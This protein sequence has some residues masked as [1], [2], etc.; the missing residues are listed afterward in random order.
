[1]QSFKNVLAIADS[2]DRENTIFAQAAHLAA[3]NRALLTV[4]A[5]I[6]SIPIVE[7]CGSDRQSPFLCD[8]QLEEQI[9][10]RERLRLEALAA[11]VREAGFEIKTRILRGNASLEIIR[12]VVRNRHD[13]VMVCADGESRLTCTL[14]GS[15]CIDLMRRCPCPVLAIKPTQSSICG[16]VIAAVDR[17]AADR[18]HNALNV[19]I[20]ELAASIAQVEHG[21]LITLHCWNIPR[22][23]NL[24]I[25]L[26]RGDMDRMVSDIQHDHLAWLDDLLEQCS[27]NHVRHQVHLLEGAAAE[28]IPSEAQKHK[29]DVIVV[30]TA[31]GIGIAGLVI[32]NMAERILR[33]VGCAVLTVKPDT[34]VTPV[35]VDGLTQVAP[36]DCLAATSAWF[37]LHP[38]SPRAFGSN[39]KHFWRPHIPETAWL[40]ALPGLLQGVH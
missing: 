10:Q 26:S 18:E 32:G 40:R 4:A 37:E 38:I 17:R 3:R 5:I 15:T 30:G 21:E 25:L 9:V 1:M 29:V 7:T 36:R 20:I 16:R 11:P 19:K 22:M 28:L 27:L 33:K 8:V 12:E 13:V 6:D 35:R 2:S 31:C 39:S 34:F 24:D 14:F 23:S